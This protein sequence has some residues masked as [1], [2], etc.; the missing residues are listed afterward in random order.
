MLERVTYKN[1]LGETFDFGENGAY[2]NEN[3]LH[4]YSWK[5]KTLGGR[6]S[7]FSRDTETRT[8][9]V[10]ILCTDEADGI[11]KRNR[12]FEVVEKDV[13]ALERG[14]IIVNGF[15][16]PC[17][18]TK[19]T[20]AQYSKTDK[21]MV[22]SLEVTTDNPFWIRESTYSYTGTGI[23][24]YALEPEYLDYPHD[25]PFDFGV[26]GEN[27]LIDTGSFASANFKIIIYGSCVSPTLY[28]AGHEYSV[29]C[30][31]GDGEYLTIDSAKKK[32]YLT[33][34]DGTIVNKF[35]DRNKESYIFERI[36]AGSNPVTW[37]GTFGFDV[38]I[39]D[40]R[41]ESKWI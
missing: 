28:I 21:K 6:V 9:P 20:K 19:S 33:Q 3:D 24:A 12:L 10:V 40:E 27:E 26:S 36:P 25:F 23:S 38:T 18:I 37:D 15:Y 1:H 39:I 30:E 14:R 16:M 2:I 11:A 22:V 5:V 13:L 32:I 35:A 31:V 17:F 34:Q 41:S 29:D 4:D 7:S 8:L